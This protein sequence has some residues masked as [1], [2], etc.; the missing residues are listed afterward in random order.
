MDQQG[1]LARRYCRGQGRQQ[2][3]GSG[4]PG[5]SG[6]EESTQRVSLDVVGRGGPYPE[7]SDGLLAARPED[8]SRQPAGPKG[9]GLVSSPTC[10]RGTRQRTEYSQ[11]F[12]TAIARAW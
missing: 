7:R 2:E 8:Q 5:T 9:L 6:A 4:L 1:A 12:V 11:G 10:R 3:G